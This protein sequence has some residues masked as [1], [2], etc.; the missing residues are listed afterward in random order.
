MRMFGWMRVVRNKIFNIKNKKY[1]LNIKN[2][3][4]KKENK[5]ELLKSIIKHLGPDPLSEL[6]I[7]R[8]YKILQSSGRPVKFVLMDQGKIAG[9]GNIY[10]NECLFMSGIN[11]K[12]RA[13]LITRIK[14]DGLFNN[15]IKVLKL[16]IE[17]GGASSNLF[18]NASGEK[19]R[20]QEHL[21]V[22]GKEDGDCPNNCGEKIR[23]IKLG[24]RGTFF[25]PKC[26]I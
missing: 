12:I 5:I 1:I 16:G 21:L 18:V 26:Q 7:D 14:S 8:F 10:A 13:S 9:V 17:H 4:L 3:S 19:G 22:Y 6:S 11:P 25:C 23:R 15:L 20:M 2:D 24:G